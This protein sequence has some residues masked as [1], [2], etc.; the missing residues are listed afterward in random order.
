[1][2][3]DLLRPRMHDPGRG[4][5]CG[6][7]RRVPDELGYNAAAETAHPLTV[8]VDRVARGR[9]VVGERRQVAGAVPPV[10]L[11]VY[12]RGRAGA[13]AVVVEGVVRFDRTGLPRHELIG[14]VVAER[15]SVGELRDVAPWA[16]D[17]RIRVL[18]PQVTVGVVAVRLVRL[19]EPGAVDQ[20]DL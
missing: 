4:G 5:G 9:A 12:G 3:A 17:Q 11:C 1:R 19:T 2:V 15:R 18:G 7:V 13:L 10:A 20:R 6:R 8:P 14:G 16:P